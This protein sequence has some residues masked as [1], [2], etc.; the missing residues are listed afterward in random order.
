MMCLKKNGNHD[1]VNTERLKSVI[2][3]LEGESHM[4]RD[5]LKKEAEY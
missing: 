1:I 5:K 3:F 4:Y 2:D